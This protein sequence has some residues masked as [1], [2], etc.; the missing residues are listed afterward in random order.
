MKGEF[1]SFPLR[2]RF[3]EVLKPLK[4]DPRHHFLNRK[5]HVFLTVVSLIARTGLIQAWPATLR[6]LV[7]KGPCCLISSGSPGPAQ[8]GPQEA[9]R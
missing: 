7:Q 3:R 6:I 5:N 2:L 9:S 4:R 8:R 1:V